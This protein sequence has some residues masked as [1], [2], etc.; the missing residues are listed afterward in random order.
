M[1]LNLL[2]FMQIGQ[3][4]TEKKAL[5]VIVSTLT[6]KSQPYLVI[7]TLSYASPP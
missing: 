1:V 6:E 3:V 2:H 5:I 7:E 4:L